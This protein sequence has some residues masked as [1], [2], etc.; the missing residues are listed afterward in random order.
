ML[1]LVFSG[2]DFVVSP[3]VLVEQT[4][5]A[6]PKKVSDTTKQSLVAL[7]LGRRGMARVV[8]LFEYKD[9]SNES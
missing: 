8:S 2:L 1:I 4:R 9:A 7:E 3:S 5:M 6:T